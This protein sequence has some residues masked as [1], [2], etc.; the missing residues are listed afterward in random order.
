MF[1]DRNLID[2]IIAFILIVLVVVAGSAGYMLIENYSLIDAVY[3]TVITV[4][5][6]GF[7]EVNELT[8]EGKIFTIFLII[9]SFGVLAYSISIITSH[10][11]EGKLKIFFQSNI[12]KRGL[13]KMKDHIIIC[14]YGRNGKQTAHDLVHL[15]KTVVV[16]EKNHELILAQTKDS[17]IFIEGDAT[18][19]DILEKAGIQ[20]AFALISTLPLDADNLYVV[21]TARSLNADIQI[22]SRASHDSSDKKLRTAGAQHVVMPEKVGGTFMASLVAKPDLAEFFHRL[23]IEGEEG[24]NL[25]EIVCSDLPSSFQNRTIH[26]MSIRRL[27][28]A[29]IVGF[30][31]PDGSYIVN[32]P[33]D[34]V[35]VRNGKLFLLGTPEQIKK[36]R[37]ILKPGGRD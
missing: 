5:T 3:M 10:I 27:T 8:T 30:K 6:V 19:D 18:E 21:L 22:I 31:T 11:I 2:F 12:K 37:E 33:A 14:G 1:R 16:V 7:R 36:V 9:I 15:Q 29:N 32:P 13:R 4:A 26:D 23:T 28:G 17:I 35:M 20:Q 34:T 24:V 25:V